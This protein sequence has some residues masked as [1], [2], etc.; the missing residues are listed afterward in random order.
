MSAVHPG[1]SLWTARHPDW[2]PEE[3]GPEGWDP[4]VTS[5]MYEARDALLLVPR[6]EAFASARTR[7]STRTRPE[8]LREALRPILDLPLEA[9]LLTHGEPVLENAREK[10][11]RALAS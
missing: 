2:T 1:L 9:V 5:Y 8:G 11:E 7:G 10:L 6:M 4:E 3:G